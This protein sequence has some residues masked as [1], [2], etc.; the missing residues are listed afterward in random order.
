MATEINKN[1]KWSNT[2]GIQKRKRKVLNVPTIN[3]IKSIV[4]LFV[5]AVKTKHT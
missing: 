5:S 4:N 2:I 1:K 3:N